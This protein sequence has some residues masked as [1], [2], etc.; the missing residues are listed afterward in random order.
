MKYGRM[1]LNRY[2]L[3]SIENLTKDG[4]SLQHISN[5]TGIKKTT[6]YYHTRKLKGKSIQM[7]II[8]F[9]SDEK[10]GE[11]IGIFTGDGSLYFEPG[12]YHYQVRVHFGIKNL[13]YLN[14][15]KDLFDAS[16]GKKFL[17][18]MDGPRKF[19]LQIYS[20][21]IFAF[22]HDFLDFE[23]RD[24]SKSVSLK[25]KFLKNEVFAKGF[26]RGLLDTDGTIS[27]TKNGIKIAFYTSSHKLA[28]QI[29]FLLKMFEIRHGITSSRKGQYNVYILKKDNNRIVKLLKPFKGR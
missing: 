13:N 6:I 24:K 27:K 28:Q 3:K 12:R 19:V 22:F 1:R 26:L 25:E 4:K 7:P 20:K 29:S 8:R 10:L 17:I 18:K 14:H 15:V 11:A 23:S 21:E 5:I 16:F 2:Q 9:D